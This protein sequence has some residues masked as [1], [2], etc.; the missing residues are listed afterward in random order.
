[1]LSFVYDNLIN[2]LYTAQAFLLLHNRYR[3]YK[4]KRIDTA[5]RYYNKDRFILIT[6]ENIVNLYEAEKRLGDNYGN[7]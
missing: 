5:M 2:Q 4:H 3:K 1:M 7:D 6:E